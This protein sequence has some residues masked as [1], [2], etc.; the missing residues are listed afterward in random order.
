IVAGLLLGRVDSPPL[1]ILVHFGFML[2]AATAFLTLRARTLLV[3]SVVWAVAVPTLSFLV[4][5]GPAGSDGSPQ[6]PGPLWILQPLVNLGLTSSYPVLIW[7]AY[8]FVGLAIGR[9]GLDVARRPLHLV[10]VGAAVAVIGKAAS[11][12]LLAAAGGADRLAAYTEGLSIYAPDMATQLS[13]GLPGTTPTTDWRWLL[14][15]APHS[16]TTFDLLHTGGAAVAILGLCL[17]LVRLIG[18]RTVLPLVAAGSMT[19]TLYTAHVLA[20]WREG[21]LLLDD[22]LLLYLAHVGVAVAVALLW[23]SYVGR[24]PLEWA[25]SRCDRM[26][27]A[28]VAPLLVTTRLSAR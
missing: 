27:R 7:L 28:A 20:L 11:L 3:L 4:R 13:A 15:S 21:P 2:L 6:L 10:V 5:T 14:V 18:R 22:P 9:S 19:L 23:R 16:S 8:L 26:A 17:L 24:G 25:A 1:V 12:F